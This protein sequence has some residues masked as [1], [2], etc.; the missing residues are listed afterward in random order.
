[1]SGKM[2]LR[3]EV[4][5]GTIGSMII[6]AF[7][8]SVSYMLVISQCIKKFTVDTVS[9]TTNSLNGQ[10]SAIFTPYEM[11]LHDVAL[12]AASGADADVLD[13]II[14]K[15]EEAL[16]G[17]ANCDIYYATAVSRYEEGGFFIDG[18]DWDPDS[19]WIPSTRDWWK[20][21]LAANGKVAYGEPYVDAMG[22]TLCIT[23]SC[24]AYDERDNLL[25]VSAVDIY[26]HSLSEAVKNIKISENSK[27]NII[28]KEGLY[29]TN[30]ESE[31]IMNK[32]YFDSFSSSSYNKNTYLDGKVKFFIENGNF[33]GVQPVNQADWFIVAEG[34]ES[35]FSGI[36]INLIGYVL[37]GLAVIILVMAVVD[38]ILSNRV[39]KGFKQLASGCELIARGDFTQKYS[40][41]YTKELSILANG[42]NLFSERLQNIIK[43][44]KQS[45]LSLNDAGS[46]LGG[47]TRDAKKAIEQISSSIISWGDNLKSQ[48][49][50]VEQT[51]QSVSKILQS[52]HSLETLVTEQAKSVSGA[53]SA[54][55]QMIG[56]ISEVNRSVDKMA[57]CF[58]TLETDAE[59]GAQTQSELQE[60]IGE[61]E[62]QSMLLSEAN[63]T[64]ANIASQTNLLAMNAAIEAA[65]A[66]EAGKGFAV[67]ADEIRKLSETSSSQSKT[68]GEQLNRIQATIAA[69]VQSTQRGVQDYSNLANK[70]H[71]TDTLVQQIKVAMSEQQSGSAQITGALL[72][73]NESTQQVQTASQAM[74]TDSHMIM[75]AVQSLQE[76]TT[77][78][79]QDMAEMGQSAKMI[80][81]TSGAL[82]EISE[83]MENSISEIGKQVD[84]FEA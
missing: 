47:T 31:A 28:S 50:S 37:I 43:S 49:S 45:K 1:M 38:V 7:F 83:L 46:K 67:V 54:V 74:T 36:Y 6:V 14:H 79:K 11:R 66:G 10:I 44:M 34:P 77:A 15:T 71:E 42:F 16:G 72:G 8:L 58:S 39:S 4:L 55:E 26:L 40:D 68:I 64:I 61:I 78:M 57:T 13:G 19:D 48:N 84:Q 5:I 80:L 60:Q 32:N 9:R 2:S 25:G 12:A 17:E 21:A 62:N 59:N 18:L 24:A 30:E 75:D 23:L 70:I 82:S 53:S 27:I 22:G 76:K 35:D 33:Y 73:M 41:S 3:R 52:I 29:L 69:V 51:S 81:S 20:D 56:N 63:T 65:H